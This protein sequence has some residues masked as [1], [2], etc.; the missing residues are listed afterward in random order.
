VPFR[1]YVAVEEMLRY[2]GIAQFRRTRVA[3]EDIEIDGDGTVLPPPAEMA[4]R[5]PAVFPD[6]DWLDVRRDGRGHAV[7]AFGPAS[8]LARTRLARI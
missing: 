8:A 2:L 4:N 5:D 3:L 6:P 7:F 1:E